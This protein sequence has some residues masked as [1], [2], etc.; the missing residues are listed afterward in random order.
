MGNEVSITRVV[1]TTGHTGCTG[2][3]VHLPTPQEESQRQNTVATAVFPFGHPPATI[4]SNPLIPGIFG[5]PFKILWKN[6]AAI[7]AKS[8]VFE[9]ETRWRLSFYSHLAVHR[10][11]AIH[12][13]SMSRLSNLFYFY[14][15]RPMDRVRDMYMHVV[16]RI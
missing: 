10:L 4:M 16:R 11:A 13:R 9:F 3:P 7:L 5:N 2:I 14:D 1:K 12:H 15:L 6:S 8:S